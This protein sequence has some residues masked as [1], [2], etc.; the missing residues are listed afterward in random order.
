MASSVESIPFF[1]ESEEKRKSKQRLKSSGN[2]L[3]S[4]QDR[5][6]SPEDR[7]REETDDNEK[8]IGAGLIG[9]RLRA[10]SASR[11]TGKES[12]VKRK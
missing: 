6:D 3:G 4:E 8:K 5:P 1:V 2:S 12:V 9:R 11:A 10:L 7:K